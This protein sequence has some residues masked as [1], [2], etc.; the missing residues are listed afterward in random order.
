MCQ[1]VTDGRASATTTNPTANSTATAAAAANDDV[2]DEIIQPTRREVIEIADSTDSDDGSHV[3]TKPTRNQMKRLKR[4]QEDTVDTST[5]A[6]AAPEKK[7]ARES[8][9]KIAEWSPVITKPTRRKRS[10]RVQEDTVHASAAALSE[11]KPASKSN[12]KITE[13]SPG[14]TK[15]LRNRRSKRVQE[16]TVHASA[17]ALSEEKP[18][19]K[20]GK[21]ATTSF[22]K[23]KAKKSKSSNQ[24]EARS[25]KSKAEDSTDATTAKQSKKEAAK[26]KTSKSSLSQQVLAEHNAASFFAKRKQ[27]QMEERERQRKRE[28]AR[29]SSKKKSEDEAGAVSEKQEGEDMGVRFP[30]FSHVIQ[31]EEA[32]ALNVNMTDDMNRFGVLSYPSGKVDLA[33]SSGEES[34]PNLAFFGDDM[35]EDATPNIHHLFS[36]VFEPANSKKGKDKNASTKLWTDK[37]TISQIPTSILGVSNQQSASKLSQFIEEWKIRRHKSTLVKKSKSKRRKSGYD[38]DDSFLDEDGGGRTSL[39]LLTGPTGSG[40]SRLVHAISASLGCVIME[41]NTSEVR[42]GGMLKRRVLE[43]TQSHSSVALMKKREQTVGL[44]G[45]PVGKEKEFFDEESESS[46]EEEESSSLTVI[47]IDEGKWW[48]SAIIF[49]ICSKLMFLNPS[50]NSSGSVIPK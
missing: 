4:M 3:I 29:R 48:C 16:D 45:K 50:A 27:A 7:S 6:A 40:K 38:S 33:A 43:S 20:K 9:N 5:A 19:S 49:I 39:F 35:P 11:E 47:L 13:W 36:S 44:L 26:S 21:Q 31:G 15:P 30:T 12:K 18:A 41:I 14:I 8:D 42:G 32:D 34:M 46:D 2:I 23:P 1:G 28:E 17:A 22:F 24:K 37:H 10:K 25:K